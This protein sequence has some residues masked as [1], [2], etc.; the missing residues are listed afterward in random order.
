MIRAPCIGK[1]KSSIAVTALPIGVNLR[2]QFP[3]LGRGAKLDIRIAATGYSTKVRLLTAT[4]GGIDAKS[5][6]VTPNTK[7]LRTKCG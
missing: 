4:S 6:C 1:E 7:K 3:S 5:R 2:K